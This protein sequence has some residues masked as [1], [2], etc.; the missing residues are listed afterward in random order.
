MDLGWVSTDSLEQ[1]LAAAE[2]AKSRLIGI[3]LELLEE[4]DRRQVATADGSRSL[5][6]WVAAR[7]DLGSPTLKSLVRT[8]RRS[9][10][11]PDLR[12]RL[13]SGVSFDRIEAVSKVRDRDPGN[14]M[15]WTDVAGVHRKAAQQV[16][17]TADAES[18]S[19]GDRF[20]VM[21]PNLDKS[22]WKAWGGFDG[23][24]GA[25][26][27]KVLT[28][29]ADSLSDVEGLTPDTG[30]KKA[31]AL[32]ECLVSD[33]PPPAQ[34]TVTVDPKEATSTK[35]EAGVTMESGSRVGQQA[36]EAVLCDSVTEVTGRTEDGR[37]MDYGRRQRTAPP[38]LKR[39]LLAE[40]GYTCSAD[41]CVS[42]HRL[43]VHHIISWAQGGATDQDNLVVLC[44]YHHH[45][46]VHD[47]GFE[48]ILYPDRRRVRFKRP[49][50]GPPG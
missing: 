24:A 1:Q 28:E 20:F 34:L 9:T 10:D 22:W 47:R 27:D 29:T 39:A 13:A 32:V 35:G 30:W 21:Q 19:A 36:L 14:L 12:D 17:I 40:A 8:M 31:T 7:L 23:Y 2:E 6:E 48:I 33:D 25:L 4:L 42:R 11:Q 46:V 26:V 49:D 5:S 3:Q 37:Y 45:V 50:R 16:R 43:Q 41:G 18:R 44:W 38:A 15:F